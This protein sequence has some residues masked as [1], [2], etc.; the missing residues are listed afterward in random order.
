MLRFRRERRPRSD[1]RLKYMV[2]GLRLNLTGPRQPEVLAMPIPGM[3]EF[4]LGGRV[5][6]LA[7]RKEDAAA[8][9]ARIASGEVSGVRHAVDLHDR[10]LARLVRRC[11][12]VPG[13]ELFQYLDHDGTPHDVDSADVNA[14]L[15]EIAG[16]EFTAKDFRTWAGTLLAARDLRAAPS[17][18]KQTEARRH[19]VAAV[20]SVSRELGNTPAVCRKCYVHP[21]VI[22]AYLD[23][24]LF[25][26]SGDDLAAEEEALLEFLCGEES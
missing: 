13:D 16:A 22:D 15:Y 24:N 14:Y 2:G 26:V 12:D 10:R 6:R 3:T 25:P 20:E 1:P 21:G 7:L 17:G 9:L 11:Q 5:V 4:G 23:G 18:V 8:T 19:V